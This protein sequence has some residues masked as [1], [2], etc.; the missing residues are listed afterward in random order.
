[1]QDVWRC[2]FDWDESVPQNMHI[3]WLE[4]FET[5]DQIF[6]NHKLLVEECCNVQFHRFCDASSSG[7]DVCIYI[8]S[9]KDRNT[10]RL[11]CAKS[12]VASLKSTTIPRF[13]LCALLLTRLYREVN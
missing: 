4:Q 9:G 11:L 1:M 7:Y 6:F 10:V 5:I 13:E 12:R 8:R 3:A 2:Q